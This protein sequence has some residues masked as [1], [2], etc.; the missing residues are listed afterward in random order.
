M[1]AVSADPEPEPAPN[2]APDILEA[3]R[4]AVAERPGHDVYFCNP[5]PANEA[6]YHNVWAQGEISHPQFLALARAFFEAAGLA[7]DQIDLIQAQGVYGVAH[8]GVG[9]VVGGEREALDRQQ[10]LPVRQRRIRIH[11]RE[12]RLRQVA[13][14]DEEVPAG[15]LPIS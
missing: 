1:R 10:G 5:F 3:W 8:G 9:D 15:H 11:R 14:V 2:V 4:A 6:L 13:T 12:P 7:T